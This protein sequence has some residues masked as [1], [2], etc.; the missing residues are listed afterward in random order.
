MKYKPDEHMLMAYLYDELEQDEKLKVEK[1]LDQNPEAKHEFERMQSMRMLLSNL[2]D[3][4]VIEPPIIQ[5]KGLGAWS[6]WA[7]KPFRAAVGIA[8]TILIVMIAGKLSNVQLSAGNGEFRLSF[9]QPVEKNVDVAD[10]LTKE[11][12]NSMISNS[13]QQYRNKQETEWQMLQARL[14]ESV[15]RNLV[16]SSSKIDAVLGKASHASQEQIGQYI[17]LMQRQN[18]MLMQDYLA[19]TSAEQKQYMEGLLVDF[20]SY[21]QQ[22]RNDDLLYLQA[23]MNL[24]EDD[25]DLFK[26]ET[27]Q[28]LTSIVSNVSNTKNY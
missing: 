9:G 6:V 13:L 19:L 23:R 2:H 4:E 15:N 16:Q 8:A 18:M 27:E 28:I 10:L 14:D 20:A 25:T 3:K 7:W 1:Y 24:I 12:V 21:L 11:E 22:Q 26:L 17:E 5:A